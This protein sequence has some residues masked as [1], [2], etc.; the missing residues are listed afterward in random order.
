MSLTLLETLLCIDAGRLTLRLSHHLNSAPIFLTLNKLPWIPTSIKAR[1]LEWKMRLDLIN[2]IARGC[3]PLQPDLLSTYKPRDTTLV[4]KPS[5]LLSR[6][7]T[8]DD[9]GHII[10]V[11]RSLMIAQEVSRSYADKDWLRIRDDGEWLAAH[12]LLVDGIEGGGAT[13]VRQTGFPQAWEDMPE[14]TW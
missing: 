5:D 6:F 3:P 13:W 10:K 14:K 8:A 7:H 2:Y 4:A 9:D 1:L 11:A 12:Y